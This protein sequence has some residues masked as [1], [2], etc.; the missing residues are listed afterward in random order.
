MKIGKDANIVVPPSAFIAIA[1]AISRREIFA[2]DGL[3]LV[4]AKRS[5]SDGSK[6][7]LILPPMMPIVA[8]VLPVDRTMSSRDRESSKLIG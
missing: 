6:P 7:I 4:S 3:P 5:S 1:G 2:I 8:G